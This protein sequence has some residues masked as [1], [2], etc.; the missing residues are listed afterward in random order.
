MESTFQYEYSIFIGRMQPFHMAH[1]SL[2]QEALK[3]A[4]T[5]IIVIGSYKRALHHVIPFRAK[6]EKL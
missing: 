1:Y 4:R 5:A 3:L 2:L 6:N